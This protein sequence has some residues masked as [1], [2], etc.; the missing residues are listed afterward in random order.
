MGA[1]ET[2]RV[3]IDPGQLNQ[4]LSQVKT[5]S[6]QTSTLN[7]QINSARKSARAAGINLD[8]LPTL[9]RDARLLA[10]S[11]NIP[12]FREA[13]AALFQARRGVRAGQ[14][15]REAEAIAGLDPVLAQQLTTQSLLGQ[16]ALVAF[17][18]KIVYDTIQRFIKEEAARNAALEDLVRNGL[19]LSHQEFEA[20]SREQTGFA[21]FLDQFEE[22][23]ASEGLKQTILTTVQEVLASF[24]S[25]T[26]ITGGSVYTTPRSEDV[27]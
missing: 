7:S 17:V 1:Q 9:N 25:V 5:A 4:I 23:V 21:S 10:N 15:G 24:V 11:L 8:D 16:A 22:G 19:D 3:I 13:S 2:L 20:L 26:P 27:P 12:G 18:T 6:T 14:L